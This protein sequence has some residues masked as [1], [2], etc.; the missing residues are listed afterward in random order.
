MI[1]A[2]AIR[3]DDEGRE[4]ADLSEDEVIQKARELSRRSSIF[5]SA[6]DGDGK[7]PSRLSQARRD[8][9]RANTV[10]RER[11]AI[12]WVSG[13]AG[14]RSR[15]RPMQKT[16]VVRIERV[17]RH[18]ATSASSGCRAPQAHDETTR[19]GRR[20]VPSRR[21]A[22]PKE[23]RWADPQGSEPRV[24]TDDPTALRCSRRRQLRSQEGPVASG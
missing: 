11:R 3:S 4:V 1:G 23:Q 2:S 22:D 9:A 19:A 13:R 5:V 14:G 21:P 6:L 7:N 18:P 17:F 12:P 24:L 8:L 16:R 15:V 10:L 20:S